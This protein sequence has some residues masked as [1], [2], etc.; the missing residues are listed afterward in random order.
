M[1][2]MQ[3]CLTRPD[4]AGTGIARPNARYIPAPLRWRPSRLICK[5][6][7]AHWSSAS[8]NRRRPDSLQLV[9][10][11]RSFARVWC[12][13]TRLPVERLSPIAAHTSVGTSSLSGRS[14]LAVA[15]IAPDSGCK[16]C[17]ALKSNHFLSCIPDQ[18]DRLAQALPSRG[19]VL[20][21]CL[22]NSQRAAPSFYAFFFLTCQFH[23]TIA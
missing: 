9:L 3:A 5:L 22:V 11:S 2:R 8:R 1:S 20:S 19:S 7:F 6:V 16:V 18:L 23:R 13:G 14:P 15:G 12:P 4:G 10:V 17:H 21:A